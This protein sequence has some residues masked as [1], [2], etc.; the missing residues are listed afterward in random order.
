[1]KKYYIHNGTEQEG[2][3]D[4]A[5]LK[6]KKI[7]KT[8]SIWHEGL[9]EWTTADKIEELKELFNSVPPP[10]KTNTPP[11]ISHKVN[12]ETKQKKTSSWRSI[13]LKTAITFFIIV[14][15]IATI[16]K[17]FSREPFVSNTY[18]EKVMTVEEME[19]AAPRKFLEVTGKVYENFWGDKIKIK[20]MVS[21]KATVANFKDVV[22][23]V[24]FYSKTKSVITTEKYVLYEFFNAHSEKEFFLKITNWKGTHSVG[25]VVVGAVPN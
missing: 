24:T 17:L 2:P 8:T 5:A 7:L 21:N 6:E 20:G 4:V 13:F 14:G 3:F 15:I 25:C 16:N 19:R 22:L 9:P 23:E 10:F 1:M 18:E 11:P 12:V